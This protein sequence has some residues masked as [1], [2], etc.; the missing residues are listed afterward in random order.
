MKL[1]FGIFL[2]SI[3]SLPSH[4]QQKVQLSFG[5]QLAG[6]F[7]EIRRELTGRDYVLFKR[8]QTTASG[9][10]LLVNEVIPNLSFRYGLGLRGSPISSE[11]R[12]EDNIKCDSD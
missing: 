8:G 9:A 10:L 7:P 1:V 6:S 11:L 3:I 5:S 4:G 12:F 2:L